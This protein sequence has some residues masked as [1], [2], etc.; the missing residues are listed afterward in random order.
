MLRFVYVRL[1]DQRHEVVSHLAFLSSL[2]V[3]Q[4]DD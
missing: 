1:G 4:S 3:Y 2:D